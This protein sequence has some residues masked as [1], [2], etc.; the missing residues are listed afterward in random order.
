MKNRLVSLVSIGALLTA[1]IACNMSTANMSSLKVSKDKEGK[2]ET[3]SFKAGD[4]LYA[5]ATISNSPGKVTVVYKVNADEVQGMTKGQTVPGTEVKLDLPSSGVASYSLPLPA[6][7]KGGKY[8][9]VADMLNETGE[10]KD[11]KSSNITIEA[12]SAAPPATSNSNTSDDED[13]DDN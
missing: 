2:Q 5:A 9:L 12:S 7:V 1:A 4:T 3:T 8:V 10:K 11:G 13:K 6:G